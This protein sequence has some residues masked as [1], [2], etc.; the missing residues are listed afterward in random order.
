MRRYFQYILTT[1]KLALERMHQASGFVQAGYQRDQ[2]DWM[3]YNS[4]G[5]LKRHGFLMGENIQRA[6]E[7]LAIE[8]R[9]KGEAREFEHAVH[10]ITTM[11]SLSRSLEHP[12]WGSSGWHD[13]FIANCLARQTSEWLLSQDLLPLAQLRLLQESFRDAVASETPTRL[14][15]ADRCIDIARFQHWE[16]QIIPSLMWDLWAQMWK[17]NPDGAHPDGEPPWPTNLVAAMKVD[18]AKVKDAEFLFYLTE[19]ERLISASRLA[20]PQ[21]LQIA[22]NVTATAKE[23]EHQMQNNQVVAYAPRLISIKAASVSLF[24]SITALRQVAETAMAVEQY[25]TLHEGRLPTELNALVPTYLA[26][27]PTDP[28]DGRPLRFRLLTRGYVIYSIG[29]DGQDNGGKDMNSTGYSDI[30]FNVRR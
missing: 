8:A 26:A 18:F 7:V 6:A 15:I 2:R 4:D 10:S 12:S 14:L 28:F 11:V 13:S 25:R 5:T 1:N 20:L 16:E 19:M 17:Q 9:I 3:F 22:R 30:T 27:V 21:A 29:P 23:R 24:A